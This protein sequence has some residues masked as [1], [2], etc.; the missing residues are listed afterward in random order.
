VID[1]VRR[2]RAWLDE[3]EEGMGAEVNE[4]EGCDCARY[5]WVEGSVDRLCGVQ[6]APPCAVIGLKSSLFDIA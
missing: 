5:A 6:R 1:S 3:S 4:M 2:C